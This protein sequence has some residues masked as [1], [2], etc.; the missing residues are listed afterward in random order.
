M[1]S[2]WPNLIDEPVSDCAPYDI[3]STT[4]R[5][6]IFERFLIDGLIELD[7]HIVERDIRPHT[8]I[9]THKAK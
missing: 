9:L 4:V 7:S 2:I 6:K 1:N 5:C 8:I 3:R